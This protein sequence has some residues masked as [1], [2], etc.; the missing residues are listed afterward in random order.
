MEDET[1]HV[2]PSM[3][4]S[5][6]SD[7]V[8]QM[9]HDRLQSTNSTPPPPPLESAASSDK[10]RKSSLDIYYPYQATSSNQ[11]ASIEVDV[12]KAYIQHEEKENELLDPDF[13]TERQMT[14]KLDD[15]LESNERASLDK[16][17]SLYG[18]NVKVS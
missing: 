6:S 4:P 10:L 18:E 5:A 11:H 8:V 15:L 12:L 16:R 14:A 17:L 2:R 9:D 1:Y 13:K 3:V 7:Y